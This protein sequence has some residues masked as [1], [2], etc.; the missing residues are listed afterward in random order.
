MK[1]FMNRLRLHPENHLVDRIG[2]LRA[3]VLGANDGIIS[4]K[5]DHWRRRGGRDAA[6]CHDC[7]CRECDPGLCGRSHVV[8]TRVPN[9]SFLCAA[10]RPSDR[11]G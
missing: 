11:N 5:L 7:G 10:V 4:R 9:G 1:E 8:F 2:W 6:R 3:V